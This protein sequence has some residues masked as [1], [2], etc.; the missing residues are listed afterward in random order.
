MLSYVVQMQQVMSHDVVEFPVPSLSKQSI[1][2][3]GKLKLSQPYWPTNTRT[4]HIHARPIVQ[5]WLYSHLSS[6]H[7]LHVHSRYFVWLNSLQD[8][9]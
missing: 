8:H 9:V 5:Q 4:M 7:V 6:L 1:I 2:P 3:V